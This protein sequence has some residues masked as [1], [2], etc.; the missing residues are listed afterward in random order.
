[1]GWTTPD[2]FHFYILPLEYLLFAP[3]GNRMLGWT[4]QWSDP[5]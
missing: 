2:M 4:G 5:V 3:D 1:M